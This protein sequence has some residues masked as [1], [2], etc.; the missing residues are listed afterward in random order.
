VGAHLVT[1]CAQPWELSPPSLQ[2]DV[3]LYLCGLSTLV[4]HEQQL[5]K[6]CNYILK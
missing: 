4:F 1:L 3:P 5:A 2:A 6:D